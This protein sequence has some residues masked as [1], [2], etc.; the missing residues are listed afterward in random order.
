[1]EGLGNLGFW[2]AVG[3]VIAAS[4]IAGGLKERG[5]ERERQ[6]TLR[7][8]MRLEAE[9]KLSPETLKYMREKDAAERLAAEQIAADMRRGAWV[10]PGFLAVVV[11]L[12]SFMGGL[13]I[14][15]LPV[16]MA[17][18]HTAASLLIAI[19]AMLAV[20]VGGLRLA[21]LIYGAL[22][23]WKKAPPSGA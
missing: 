1:M 2:L 12:L 4:I 10:L 23:G 17:G 7:E 15:A 21:V 3:I 20:W 18:G 16:R 19:P 13:A 8:M 6:A 14:F 5:K 9:G 22:R 11:G